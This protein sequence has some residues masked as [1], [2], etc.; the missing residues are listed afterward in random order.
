[1]CARAVST[2]PKLLTHPAQSSLVWYPYPGDPQKQMCA[3]A[4]ST[5]PKP[6]THSACL[7]QS[8]LFGNRILVIHENEDMSLY[9]HWEVGCVLDGSFL[10]QSTCLRHN[11]SLSW[12]KLALMPVTPDDVQ[13]PQEVYAE[14]KGT[15]QQEHLPPKLD[16][17]CFLPIRLAAD[18]YDVDYLRVP[19]TDEKA[20]KD[21]DFEELIQRLWAVPDDAGVVFNCQWY[22]HPGMFSATN[23]ALSQI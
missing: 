14:L 12:S 20:P 4:V 22:L 5:A 7:A 6:S 8:S 3:R 18:G 2:D 11:C 9:D 13:T 23:L 21:N 17:R 16:M 1:M 19:V 15:K 10:R